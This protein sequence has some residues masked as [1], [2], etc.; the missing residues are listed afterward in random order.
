MTIKTQINWFL[1]HPAK[2]IQQRW[3]HSHYTSS[4]GAN[5]SPAYLESY[6][7]HLDSSSWFATHK[8]ATNHL[9]HKPIEKLRYLRLCW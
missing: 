2:N 5:V 6:L 1:I 7:L 8:Y 3:I 9:E 4:K